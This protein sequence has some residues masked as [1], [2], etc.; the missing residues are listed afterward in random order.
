MRRGSDD[1]ATGHFDRLRVAGSSADRSFEVE[2]PTELDSSI[3]C[4]DL[5]YLRQNH[6]LWTLS[7]AK[8]VTAA[9]VAA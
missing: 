6:G 7:I 1:V 2:Q 4:F 8:K 5:P 3:G 9:S